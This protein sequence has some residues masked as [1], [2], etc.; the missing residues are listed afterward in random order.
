MGVWTFGAWAFD[1]GMDCRQQQLWSAAFSYFGRVFFS[2]VRVC[3]NQ[4]CV[5]CGCSV[6]SFYRPGFCGCGYGSGGGAC[7]GVGV[8]E[9]FGKR[10]VVFCHLSYNAVCGHQ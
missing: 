1:C 5:F 6:L 8:V 4:F 7:A 9:R 10:F 2:A 3:E